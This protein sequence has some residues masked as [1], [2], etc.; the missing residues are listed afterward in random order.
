MV[1]VLYKKLYTRFLNKVR[2]A[3][4]AF[5]D[6]ELIQSEFDQIKIIDEPGDVNP[7]GFV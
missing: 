4:K 5:D 1:D 7:F 6:G 3:E 2:K